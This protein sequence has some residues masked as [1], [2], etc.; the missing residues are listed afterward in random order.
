MVDC[1]GRGYRCVMMMLLMMMPGDRERD[2]KDMDVDQEEERA[3]ISFIH[4]V[5]LTLRLFQVDHSFNWFTQ[6]SNGH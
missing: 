5:F 4:T 6:V 2:E 3:F 1:E